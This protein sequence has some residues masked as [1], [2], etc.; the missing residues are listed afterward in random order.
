M[1]ATSIS[2]TAFPAIMEQI[3]II[4]FLPAI[5]F[6]TYSVFPKRNTMVDMKN[7][8]F[9]KAEKNPVTVPEI[10]TFANFLIPL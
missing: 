9:R 3:K 10:S 4:T 7:T 5:M 8:V 2:N 6:C 1:L